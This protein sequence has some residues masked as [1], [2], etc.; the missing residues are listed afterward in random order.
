MKQKKGIFGSLLSLPAEEDWIL[1]GPYADKS[2]I[3]NV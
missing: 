1:H 2:L 3:R